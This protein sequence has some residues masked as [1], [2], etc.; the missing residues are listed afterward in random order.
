MGLCTISIFLNKLCHSEWVSYLTEIGKKVLKAY[1]GKGS[2]SNCE[3][4]DMYMH[5]LVHDLLAG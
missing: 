1:L 5:S 4:C 2:Y 3:L